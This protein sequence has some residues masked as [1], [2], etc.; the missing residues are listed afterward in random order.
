MA[1]ARIVQLAD[2]IVGQINAGSFSE[3]FVAERRFVPFF[4]REDMGDG[5]HVIVVP[6]ERTRDRATR[7]ASTHDLSI[8]LAVQQ[9]VSD[10]NGDRVD[11][12]LALV[13]ELADFVDG[14]PI[15][16]TGHRVI[17]VASE[18]IYDPDHLKTL[19]VFT[20]LLTLT[21]REIT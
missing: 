14:A 21:C 2:G 10:I 16:A 18:P 3:A 9:A 19:S 6:R 17:G 1:N 7:S 11:E 20:G 8:D 4:R 13:E 5:L 12:L 15:T